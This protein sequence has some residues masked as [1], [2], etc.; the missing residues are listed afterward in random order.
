MDNCEQQYTIQAKLT[1]HKFTKSQNHQVSPFPYLYFIRIICII[2]QQIIQYDCTV[3][4]PVN[5][6]P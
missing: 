1:A 6:L 2:A 5:R 3:R 4:V